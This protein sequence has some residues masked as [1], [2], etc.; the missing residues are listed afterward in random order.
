MVSI[1]PQDL[2]RF[3]MRDLR[4]K[5]TLDFCGPPFRI[6]RERDLQACCYFHLRTFLTP[7]PTWEICAEP[8]L[9]ALKRASR[10]A[11]PDVALLQNGHLKA[12]I[13]L[14]FRRSRRGLTKKDQH[15][16]KRAVRKGRYGRWVNKAYYIEVVVKPSKNGRRKGTPYRNRARSIAMA[17]DRL[18]EFLNLLKQRR[19]ISLLP[20]QIVEVRAS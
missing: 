13:E 20:P 4:N 2:G 5:L 3:I 15:V 11:H 17:V 9:R 16:L 8:C 7:D 1:T 10:A 14:K 6:F 18:D 19:K 12:L